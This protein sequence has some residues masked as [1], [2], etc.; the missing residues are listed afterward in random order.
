MNSQKEKNNDSCNDEYCQKNFKVWV[1]FI[2]G[3]TITL[4]GIVIADYLIFDNK[5]IRLGTPDD[6]TISGNVALAAGEATPY[7]GVEVIDVDPV[8]IENFDIRGNNGVL[9]NRIVPNSPADQA[10]IIR[11]DVIL[12]FNRQKVTDVAAFKQIIADSEVGDRVKVG[13]VR[14]SGREITY[15]LIGSR[16]AAGAVLLTADSPATLGTVGITASPLTEDFSQRYGVVPDTQGVG[17]SSVAP[18]SRAETAGLQPGDVVTS[19]NRQETPDV[20]S[21]L[22]ALGSTNSA[23]LD[24]TRGSDQVY[25]TMSDTTAPLSVTPSAN[26]GGGL[27]FGATPTG[28]SPFTDDSEEEEGGYQGKPELLPPQGSRTAGSSVAGSPDICKCLY[29]G[30]TIVHPVG[31]P[32]TTIKC[33]NCGNFMVS[34]NSAINVSGMPETI[35]PMGNPENTQQAAYTIVALPTAG[36]F[37]AGR[38]TA[39]APV[40]GMPTAGAFTAG[41]P[42]AGAPVAGMPTAG[43][44]IEGRPIAGNSPNTAGG[45]G[46]QSGQ[47][48]RTDVCVCPVCGATVAHPAG[49]PCLQLTCPNCGS[50]LLSSN[51]LIRTSSKPET[52]PPMGSPQQDAGA[53]IM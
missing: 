1:A 26:P 48:G 23:L 28:G 14:D 6:N 34:D 17:I 51:A 29:C 53:D 22:N 49:I 5:R 9:V 3:M 18:G 10:G 35:P 32:C 45:S 30:T 40:A 42:T 52:I 19:V 31:V 47:G 20:P 46:G 39:G 27:R 36:A 13:L 15:L 25:I 4:I 24:V 38:P 41:R 11:G 44:L 7:L 16:P 50:Q 43:V 12:K 2:F 21:F 8:I 37:T 33:P